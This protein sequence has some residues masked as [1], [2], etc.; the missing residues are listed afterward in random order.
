MSLVCSYYLNRFIHLASIIQTVLV[1]CPCIK[2]TLSTPSLINLI[3]L[4]TLIFFLAG[5]ATPP[6]PTVSLNSSVHQLSLRQQDHWSVKGRFGFKSPD[7]K[8]ESAS[9]RWQQTQQQYQFNLISI[10]GTS[11]LKM[12]GDEDS[13]TLVADDQTY[14]D[15]D[16]SH[17]IWRVTG[18]QI[19]VEKLR[20]WIK[21]QHQ[22]N[23]Q[24]LTSE[25]GWVSQLQPN[26]NN[27]NNWL[28]N[29]D[30]YKLV[31]GI[32]LPHKVVLHNSLNN[33]QLLI[34][35]NEWDLHE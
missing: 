2:Q 19:P 33:S 26:C 9:F 3:S 10:I 1:N 21:G 18:W 6:Q 24:V 11:L 27:C 32:W 7:K 15:S 16:P 4:I 29:Y 31:D 35:V 20:I 23:D 30:N 28:I 17:L 34:R 14:Q 8:S 13:V 5:C 12:Q 25:Q 22:K